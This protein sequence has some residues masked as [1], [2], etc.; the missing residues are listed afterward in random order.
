[1]RQKKN[2][3]EVKRQN[4]NRVFRYIKS[5]RRTSMPDIATALD[6]SVPTVL[7]NVKELRETGVIC[8]AGEF[9]STGG[10]KAKAVSSVYDARY[11]VGIE[12]TR[13]H[14]GLVL[15]DISE[16]I[17]RQA[18]LR[19]PFV[20]DDGYFQY[21][22][23]VLEEFI[24]DDEEIKS[25]MEGVGISVPAIVDGTRNYI[26][27]SK[28]LDLYDIDGAVF[29]KY[30]PYPCRLFNDANV[31]AVAEGSSAPFTDSMI[32]LSLS[33]TV[34]G[35]IVFHQDSEEDAYPGGILDKMYIGNNWHSGEF[36]HMV[37][38]PKGK[39]CYCGKQGCVDA[40]CSALCLASHTGGYLEPFFEGVENEDPKLL[41]I[42]EA[43]LDDLAIA[44]DNLRMCFDCAVVLGGYVGS[45]IEPYMKDLRK[46][47][48]A[49]RIFE[50]DEDLVRACKYQ[51][52][53]SALGAAIVYIEEY[54]EQI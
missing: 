46:R 42:W 49:K 13:N 29:S 11:A 50:E 22:G 4:R 26:T 2:N 7:Q 51:K 41:E 45:C 53:A 39:T 44:V 19:K 15:T 35:A 52:E 21:L 31:A 27:Y 36:G 12:I 34:G 8:E 10:R 54:I 1:M 40:Y 28:A 6:M 25:R 33:N 9:E 18:R 20:Y 38:H 32:Y 17:L 30:I 47:L 16:D 3:T 14:I 37:I 48:V 23:Q 5:K 24:G 43:Y